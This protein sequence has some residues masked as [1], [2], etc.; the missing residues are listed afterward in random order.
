MVQ[1]QISR[2][3]LTWLFLMLPEVTIIYLHLSS[4]VIEAPDCYRGLSALI[5]SLDVMTTNRSLRIKIVSMIPSLPL[6]TRPKLNFSRTMPACRGL[7]EQR[8]SSAR[9]AVTVLQY[10]YVRKPVP[11]DLGTVVIGSFHDEQVRT[12]LYLSEQEQPISLMFVG[13]KRR[14]GIGGGGR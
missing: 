8:R 1:C 10:S 5:A 6:P 7:E 13:K 2:I 4:I 9:T 14:R 3:T 11:P 12:V